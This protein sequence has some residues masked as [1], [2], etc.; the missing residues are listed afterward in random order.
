MNATANLLFAAAVN[1][2]DLKAALL[3]RHA[4]HPVIVHFPIALFIASA[5]FEILAAWRKQPI[6]AAVAYFNLVG[7]AFSIPFTIATGLAAWQLQLEGAALKG[8]LQLHL[9]FALTTATLIL[10]LCYRRF[11]LRSKNERPNL[12]YFVVMTIALMMITLTGH[13]GGIVAGLETP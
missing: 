2:F 11:R 12:S 6:F 10:G 3:A 4:Q 1:A 9:I 8:N 5:I 13:L 7:A